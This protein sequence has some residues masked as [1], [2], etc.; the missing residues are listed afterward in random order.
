M[1]ALQIIAEQ[2][3]GLLVAEQER[4]YASDLARLRK[5]VH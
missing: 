5:L 3:P 2:G 4:G 1:N